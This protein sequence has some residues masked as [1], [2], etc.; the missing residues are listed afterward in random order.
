[1]P[2]WLGSQSIEDSGPEA[3]Q[4][5]TDNRLITRRETVRP[6]AF[7]LA[8]T[9]QTGSLFTEIGHNLTVPGISKYFPPYV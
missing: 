5:G 2:V 6:G 4:G 8:D 9:G 3:E 1:M 7:F